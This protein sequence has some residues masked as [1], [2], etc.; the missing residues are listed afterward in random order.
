[1]SVPNL[2]SQNNFFEEII[3]ILFS[4]CET[5]NTYE[6]EDQDDDLEEYINKLIRILIE[7]LTSITFGIN[8]ISNIYGDQNILRKFAP[9][10]MKIFEYLKIFINRILEKYQAD[11]E[12]INEIILCILSYVAD[13]SG[14][15]DRHE[16]QILVNQEFVK[17]SLKKIKLSIY[18]NKHEVTIDWI[19]K[20]LNNFFN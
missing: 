18:K 17:E 12:Q 9:Y 14:M 20:T 19:E 8:D 1:M 13:V 7:C 3:L 5:C 6:S 15:Y 2:L 11:H 16:I 4:A 10:L